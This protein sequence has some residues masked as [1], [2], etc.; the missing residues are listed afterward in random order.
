VALVTRSGAVGGVQVAFAEQVDTVT[1][2]VDITAT[3]MN[4][5]PGAAG[6]GLIAAVVFDAVGVGSATLR[7]RAP[8]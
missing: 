6:G 8:R 3:R 5:S 2:R 7:T 1:G 4:D